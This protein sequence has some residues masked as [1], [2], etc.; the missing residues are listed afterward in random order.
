MAHAIGEAEGL[1]PEAETLR[2][3]LIGSVSHELRTPL[4]SI[5]GSTSVL[6]QASNVAQDAR[7]SSLVN[8]IRDETERLSNDIQNMSR[9]PAGSAVPE[10]GRILPGPSRPISSMRLWLDCSGA[11]E[12]HHIDPRLPRD[13]PLVRVDAVLVEQALSQIIDNAAKY[14]P[15][16]LTI[17]IAAQ[18]VDATVEI[19]VRD[20][21]PGL[22]ADEQTRLFERFDRGPRH[23]AAVKGSGLGLWI[24]RAFV[25]GGL[26][27]TPGDHQRGRGARERH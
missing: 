10:C 16:G 4:A 2:E 15:P 9:T 20:E 12:A 8:V 14:S 5:L 23:Q 11:W 19:A 27:R 25:V 6:S 26:W 7:L 1:A 3:A 17:A 13:L 18:A 21:G 22:T 24:A